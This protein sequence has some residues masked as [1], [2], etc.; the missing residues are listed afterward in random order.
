MGL[1]SKSL[2]TLPAG[3]HKD[4][5]GLMLRVSKDGTKRTWS[6]AYSYGTKRRKKRLGAYPAV[7]LS[8]ARKL[9]A[10]TKGQIAAG[11]DPMEAP[12]LPEQAVTIGLTVAD[13]VEQ[14]LSEGAGSLSKATQ[15]QYALY[16]RGRLVPMFGNR[17]LV[18]LTRQDVARL[19]AQLLEEGKEASAAACF[20]VVRRFLSWHTRVKATL[21]HN[22]ALTLEPPKAVKSRDR[23]LTDG[24]IAAILGAVRGRAEAGS[25]LTTLLFLTACRLNEIAKL[26]WNDVDLERG[27][28]TLPETKNGR[29]HIVPLPRQALLILR[30]QPRVGE[31][32][33]SG[34]LGRTAFS[35][36][37]KTK[38]RLDSRSGVAGWRFHDVR[39]SMATLMRREGVDRLTVQAVL[40]H[41][42]TD[43]TSIYDRHDMAAEKAAA[44]Q[45]LADALDRISGADSTHP[46][47]EVPRLT[48]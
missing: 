29:T 39:R 18:N 44:L 35:G 30:A 13:A 20:R 9:T 12:D 8:E 31:F 5:N 4:G 27:V 25:R 11:I 14:F 47:K 21:E 40:N 46:L 19:N 42:A 10:E 16:L 38:T 32:V 45:L 24:E 28:L 1:I 48:G 23:V 37:S 7:S 33:I 15:L 6:V 41:A 3:D 43:V 34:T 36:F 22:V 26:R 2:A 17:Q